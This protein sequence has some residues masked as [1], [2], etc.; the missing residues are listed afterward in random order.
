MAVEPLLVVIDLETTG[1]RPVSGVGVVQPVQLGAVTCVGGKQMLFNTFMLPTIPI[2]PT[3][4]QVNGF[5]VKDDKLAR[6]KAQG[7]G[8]EILP[9]VSV[10]EGLHQFWTWLENL[11]NESGRSILIAAHNGSGFDFP[12][13]LANM[14]NHGLTM[15][16]SLCGKVQGADTYK[17]FKKLFSERGEPEQSCKLETLLQKFHPLWREKQAHDGLKD[18][19][20]LKDLLGWMGVSMNLNPAQL[21]SKAVQHLDF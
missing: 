6:K 7:D 9:A 20:D 3:A 18:A 13:L 1:L 12:V 17:A 11:G 4:S 21:I 19:R 15:P 5:S 14:A 16:N 2:E 10:R 8:E